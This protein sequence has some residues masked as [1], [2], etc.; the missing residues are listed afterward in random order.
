MRYLQPYIEKDL[1][2]KMVFLG[3]PRQCGKTTLA[4]IIL[5]HTQK[6]LKNSSIPENYF[7]F[8]TIEDRLAILNG[9]WRGD[10][11]LI[12]F[13]E[14]HKYPKWKNWIKGQYDK[15][16][17]EHKFLV[18][19]S[20]RLDLYKRG[21]DSLMGR[22][23]Y[24]RLHPF[25]LDE[26]PKG[27]TLKNALERLLTIGG[28]P[29]PFLGN[30]ETEARRWRRERLDRVI[31]DDIRDLESIK[32]I[33]SIAMLV[34]LLK[35]RVGGLVSYANL[36]QDLQVAPQTVKRWIE[37]LEKM[38]LVFAIYPYTK[39]LPRAVLKPPKI[40]FF[41]NAD[42]E[43]DLGK[44]F[45]NLVATHLLKRIHF[46]E[47]STGHSYQL[48]YIRDKES[49][50]VDFLILKDGIVE[51]LIEVKVSDDEVSRSLQYY[52]QKL[53]PIRSTQIVLNLKRS[54][55]VDQCNIIDPI[56]YFTEKIY[57]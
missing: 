14:L 19:G 40:Y 7:N 21:G 52:T 4:K 32:D 24:W 54:F 42:V 5:L 6:P 28:F 55:R 27:V 18:T 23:H 50:E 9:K 13:D 51:E 1:S 57:W 10:A 37:V 20:A 46:L 30:D 11:S 33:Q 26:L 44:R 53:K 2:K 25:T 17:T 12:V 36:A 3:G 38:Y 31:R 22:Y 29:E 49:R 34:E 39:N 41:D 45:E 43:N 48:N 35:T 15:Y 56:R 16:H 47:D 8:D